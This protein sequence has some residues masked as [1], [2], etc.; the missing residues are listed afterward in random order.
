MTSPSS[1]A[2]RY[3]A[4]RRLGQGEVAEVLVALDR[5]HGDAEVVVKRLRREVALDR[6]AVALFER[7]IAVART[8]D[9]P[10]IVRILDVGRAGDVPFYVM[11]HLAGQ[12]LRAQM[13]ALRKSNRALVP[14]RACAVA[15]AAAR[16]LAYAHARGIIHRDVK[17]A[18]VFLAASGAVKLLDFGIAK[19]AEHIAL[20]R[21]GV[22]RGTHAYMAPEHHAG[23]ELD[24]RA[25]VFALGVVLW[26]MLTT[27]RLWKRDTPAAIV[28]AIA[29]EPAPPPSTYAR[30][31]PRHLEALTMAMLTKVPIARPPASVVAAE[32]DALAR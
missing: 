14:A 18:N 6:D 29:A 16:G 31:I 30:G 20:T 7:E 22:T 15:A 12:D 28:H 5:E 19:S 11:E 21:T 17:P 27:R 10:N 26:E 13:L 9:H 4:I 1:S 2:A 3:K 23:L 32:L 24:D 25:D 8:L